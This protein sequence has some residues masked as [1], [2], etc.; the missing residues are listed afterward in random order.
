MW[1]LATVLIFIHLCGDAS[2]RNMFAILFAIF[3]AFF[4]VFCAPG[5]A[6]SEL[7]GICHRCGRVREF[8]VYRTPEYV[9]R[10]RDYV[11]NLPQLW[12]GC[13]SAGRW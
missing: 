1:N 7:R 2:S 8:T 3:N 10:A 6:I 11:Y 9:A 13:W 4:Y 12:C 5:P